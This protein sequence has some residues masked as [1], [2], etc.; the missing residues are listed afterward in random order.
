MLQQH[1]CHL[2]V[3][4]EQQS[5][6]QRGPTVPAQ[7]R[8]LHSFVP[9]PSAQML[10][11]HTVCNAGCHQLHMPHCNQTHLISLTSL[12]AFNSKHALSMSLVSAALCRLFTFGPSTV[13][14]TPF[15]SKGCCTTEY[16]TATAKSTTANPPK[17]TRGGIVTVNGAR[18]SHWCYVAVVLRGGGGPGPFGG[19]S[20]TLLWDENDAAWT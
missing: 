5:Q 6:L 12:P 1:L 17:K 3:I 9:Q 8:H 13:T 16:E 2:R 19:R 7:A 11:C 15:G 14:Q 4:L 10:Q 20:K 18:L